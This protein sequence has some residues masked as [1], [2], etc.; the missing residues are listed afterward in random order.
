MTRNLYHLQAK[1]KNRYHIDK[2][3]M[4]LEANWYIKT[5]S[6]HIRGMYVSTEKTYLELAEII[7]ANK[8]LNKNQVIKDE[9]RKAREWVK[10]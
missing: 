7:E 1:Y 3:L 9:K 2:V 4:E 5:F 10:S 8:K 6:N